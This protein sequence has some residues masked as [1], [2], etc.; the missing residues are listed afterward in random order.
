MQGILLLG[1]LLV[2][3]TVALHIL[4]LVLLTRLLTRLTALLT[5]LIRRTVL[6]V[7]A[8]L[9]SVVVY[10]I[11]VHTLEIWLW[12]AVYFAIGEFSVFEDALY[13]S[14]VTATTLGYGDL[15][16][17]EQWRLLATFE[18][19]GGLVLFGVSTAYLIALMRNVFSEFEDRHLP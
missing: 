7:T 16:L 9:S 10:L 15:V 14:A 6:G 12:A 2:V 13:F 18:A 8:I 4:A 17:S 5:R 1:S 11:G 3:V 19:M